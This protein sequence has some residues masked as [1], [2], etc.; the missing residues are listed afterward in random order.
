MKKKNPSTLI[1]LT[2]GFPSNESD[3]T[4]L[5]SIQNFVLSV[6]RKFPALQIVIISLQYPHRKRKYRWNNNLVISLKGKSIPKVFRVLLWMRAC[7][8]LH[9]IRIEN[10]VIGI[11]SLWCLE[12]ALVGTFFSRI[13]KIKHFIWIH[14][15]D[16]RQNNPF[17]KWIKPKPNELVALS[18][19]LA[20]EFE[21][22]HKIRPAYT[23]PNGINKSGYHG[24]VL[25]KHIDM[26]AAGSLIPLKQ[27]SMFIDA[28]HEVVKS[29]PNVKA[30]IVGAGPDEKKLRDMI[31]RADLE[32]NITMTGEV[33][34]ADVIA[35]MKQSKILIHPSSYEG[36]S[37]VCLEALYAGCQVISFVKPESRKITHWHIVENL[38]EMI[39]RCLDLLNSTTD[40]TPVLVHDMDEITSQMIQLFDYRE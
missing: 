23:I 11:L 33:S 16:A 8:E 36:Y 29:K 27:Y 17:I 9:K 1:I 21:K 25:D 26:M 22:N 37:T 35:F 5:P 40:Y 20:S 6:N 12:T 15:Q 14:G 24:P 7:S 34:H 3:S 39:D 10:D 4:C 30:V 13:R 2:P 28:V 31:M 32:K 38:N 19:F 18:D